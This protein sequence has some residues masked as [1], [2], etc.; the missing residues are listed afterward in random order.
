MVDRA[1]LNEEFGSSDSVV[2]M[3]LTTGIDT[4]RTALSWGERNVAFV[5]FSVI[6][7]SVKSHSNSANSRAK[8]AIALASH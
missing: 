6:R 4:G 5:D 3:I 2:S 7:N 1:R 8:S